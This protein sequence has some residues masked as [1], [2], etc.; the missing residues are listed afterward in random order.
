MRG[1]P[2]E[3]DLRGDLR[4]AALSHTLSALTPDARDAFIDALF[5][6]PELPDD[7][8]GLPQGAVPYLPCAVDAIVHAVQHAPV[9]AHDVFVDLGA[10]LGRVTLLAHL[11]S[12]ARAVG[13]ELVTSSIATSTYDKSATLPLNPAAKFHDGRHNGYVRC[14]VT[15][16]ALRADL[17]AIADRTDARSPASVLASFE[18][19]DG[20]PRARRLS[21]T[22]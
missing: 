7:M 3:P 1:G 15:R 9:C 18:V 16:E 12:G 14:D 8:P 11:L 4:G 2:G 10:G 6:L 22:E 19:R 5:A 13:V 21:A 17:V 20:D